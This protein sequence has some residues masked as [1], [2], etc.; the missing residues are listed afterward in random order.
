MMRPQTPWEMAAAA[1]KV[2]RGGGRLDERRR[3]PRRTARRTMEGGAGGDVGH[4]AMTTT[5]CLAA[6]RVGGGGILQR[7]YGTR[8]ERW[9]A[10]RPNPSCGI[11]GRRWIEYVPWPRLCRDALQTPLGCHRRLAAAG[12][13]ACGRLR[14]WRWTGVGAR[15]RRRG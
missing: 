4:L 2:N 10:G 13:G 1:S 7:I 9:A 11:R 8:R 14:G 3:A 6:G 12:G 5:A 15:G